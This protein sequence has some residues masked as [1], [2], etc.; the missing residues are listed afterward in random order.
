MSDSNPTRSFRPGESPS[1]L[2]ESGTLNA[3]IAG[4]RMAKGLSG[5]RTGAGSGGGSGPVPATHLLV[6]AAE[7]LP[8]GAVV[9]LAE[10]LEWDPAGWP[11]K[12]AAKPAFVAGP[13][14]DGEPWLVLAEAAEEGE[15]VRAVASGAA[16][17][18]LSTPGGTVH[19][20]A[21]PVAG[22]TAFLLSSADGPA[23]VLWAEEAPEDEEERWAVVAVAHPRSA[24]GDVGY[25]S[26]TEEGIVGLAGQVMGDG[27]KT[28]QAD[29]VC[30][31]RF[32]LE[33][34]TLDAG[35]DVTAM[36]G[37]NCEW[38][39]I[40]TSGVA[41]LED[42][43]Y[44][45]GLRAST[46]DDAE[47]A[48][49]LDAILCAA[50]GVFV[51]RQVAGGIDPCYAVVRAGVLFA[52]IDIADAAGLEITGGLVTG[53]ELLP[54]SSPVPGSASSTGT[55]GQLACES[56]WLYVCVGVDEWE[57]VALATW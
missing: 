18:R 47:D 50:Q 25:A 20:R 48:F 46:E 31:T 33:P 22:E 54:A 55:P 42:P 12:A 16:L 36:P 45:T 2:L 14:V 13:P 29:V 11:E 26:R 4:G 21:E 39:A 35:Q 43:G 49:S 34:G 6:Q 5:G 44:A 30:E 1:R 7:P 8:L 17:A 41:G 53:G 24:G 52:G 40:D 51:L 23:A 19:G 56:G 27:E 15:V 3:M 9:G 38:L 32:L 10:V 37:T 28:F 57:R